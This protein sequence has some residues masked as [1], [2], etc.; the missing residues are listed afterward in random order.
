MH[1]GYERGECAL[2]IQSRPKLREGLCP[3]GRRKRAVLPEFT[4]VLLHAW[5]LPTFCFRQSWSEMFYS[6]K[7]Y[8]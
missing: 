4:S 7:K 3:E 5:L 6:T 1:V 2:C 8:T